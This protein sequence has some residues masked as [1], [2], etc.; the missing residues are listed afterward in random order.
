[1]KLCQQSRLLDIWLP[2][3]SEDYSLSS[4]TASCTLSRATANVWIDSNLMH[5]MLRNCLCSWPMYVTHLSV[6][7]ATQQRLAPG[8]SPSTHVKGW[9]NT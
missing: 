6:G 5:K 8:T 9:V 4:S 7:Q 3:E 1:M 2:S